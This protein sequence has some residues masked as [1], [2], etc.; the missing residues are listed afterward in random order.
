MQSGG[1]AVVA[2]DVVGVDVIVGVTVI[3]GAAL[4]LL[5][6]VAAEGCLGVLLVVGSGGIIVSIRSCLDTKLRS[7]T[8]V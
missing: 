6:L 8:R 4:K 5:R 3:G 2:A 7:E 1:R